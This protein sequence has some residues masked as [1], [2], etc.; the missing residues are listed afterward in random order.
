MNPQIFEL[1]ISVGPEHIDIRNH[2]N[3]LVYLQWCLE[4]AEKHWSRNASKSQ[5]EDYIW[6][7][8]KHEINYKAAAFEGEEV[9]VKT[10]VESNEGVRSERRYEIW[11]PSQNKLLVEAR[12]L[13]CLL[14][15]K[16]QR[17]HPIPE[18]ICKLFTRE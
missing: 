3:N 18:E 2:V 15:A 14:L 17:P 16:T 10:W 9:L 13:W 8:L 11:N 1:A 4:A 6:Y 12:T 5:L 7:V